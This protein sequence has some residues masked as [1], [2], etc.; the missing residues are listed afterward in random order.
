MLH[1]VHF[2]GTGL[3]PAGLPQREQNFAWGVRFLPHFGQR[4]KT[5]SWCP[6]AGQNVESAVTG[7][8]QSG[9]FMA[10][11]WPLCFMASE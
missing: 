6:Q 1:C 7:P 2:F 4:L 11:V 8:W 3:L 9:H 10:S 5:T